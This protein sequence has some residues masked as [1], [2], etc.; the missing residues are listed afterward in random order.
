MS[1][2]RAICM[3]VYCTYRSHTFALT[4]AP[5]FVVDKA[6]AQGSNFEARGRAANNC[7]TCFGGFKHK[8]D[9]ISSH[10]SYFIVHR[11][12]PWSLQTPSDLSL[13]R[14]PTSKS[15]EFFVCTPMVVEIW[16]LLVALFTETYGTLWEPDPAFAGK[17][18]KRPH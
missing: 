12:I 14:R 10:R 4:R 8:S 7:T 9:H 6:R 15:E 13:G 16:P 11:M 17:S 18:A 1:R 2:S 3:S 5:H